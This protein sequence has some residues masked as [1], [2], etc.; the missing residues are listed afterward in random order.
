MIYFLLGILGLSCSAK[1]QP[2]HA[3]Q[4]FVRTIRNSLT[5]LW[6]KVFHGP[7]IRKA[8]SLVCCVAL[9]HNAGDRFCLILGWAFPMYWESNPFIAN[10][11]SRPE[12]P[13]PSQLSLVSSYFYSI[14]IV[15]LTNCLGGCAALCCLFLSRMH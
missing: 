11:R 12:G 15:K 3:M 8:Q 9:F 14:E 2:S 4:K 6:P 1:E 13:W 5:W 10:I 7:C